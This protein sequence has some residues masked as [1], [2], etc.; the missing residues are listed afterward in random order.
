MKLPSLP[1]IYNV[2][3]LAMVAT[4]GGMLFGFDISSMSA[5][6]GTPQYLDYFNNPAGVAQGAIGSALA[7]G[8]VVGSI[9][10]GPISDKIGRRD[11]L[12][13][14][15]LWWL[16]GTT[17]QVAC[18]GRGML[19][20]GRVLNGVTVG[21]TS[22]QV[23]VY[24]AEISKHSQRGAIIII[25]QLA[26]EWGILFM[27]FIG[28]G[29]SFIGGR[30]ASFRT[31]WGIQFVPCVFLMI[32]LPFLPRSPRWL[33]KMDRTEEAIHVLAKIQAGG[34]IDD[35]YVIAEYE[36][37][38]TVLT[39]ERLAPKGWRKFIYNGMWRRTMA[40]FTVQ[41]WQQLSGANVMTYYVVYIFYMANLTGNINLISSGV[42]YALFIIFSTLMFFFVDRIG[43][44][45]L[46]V[47]GAIAMAFCHFVVGGTLGAHYTYVPEG[48]AGN[49]NVVMRV[50]GAPAHTVIAFSY[51]LII[52]YALTLAPICWVYAAE[53]WSLETRAWGMG[54]AA[55]G[56]WLFN[57]AIGLFIPPAFLNIKWKLFIV[58]GVL[59][60]GGAIQF[61]FTYPETC[62]KT[63]EEI[64]IL[65]SS[66]GPHPW[67]T[68]KGNSRIEREIEEVV[69]AQAK[70]EARASISKVIEE[71]K[72]AMAEAKEHNKETV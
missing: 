10:A 50:T 52:I 12:M 65:F 68:K 37:I 61:Y 38:I 6:I 34:R 39:A 67:N 60:L 55:I 9:I 3:F 30:T 47:W 36:E 42:Q 11:S 18:N 59:C 40:G 16:L 22:S 63:I 51:L 49:A 46:L 4:M 70:G 21:I 15:C 8:S 45:T 66:E 25:Q 44:R 48:V 26:I 14:A 71:E 54:I 13:F 69:N 20:A 23:P 35:P 58:F 62:G 64:E 56:N 29:C 2:Y 43:R 72:M 7:A 32:G 57:F 53:V 41:A 31:A 33:A 1:K 27:Y 17:V 19:I 28:Y 5:I 24:L